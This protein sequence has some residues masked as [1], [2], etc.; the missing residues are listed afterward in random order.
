[1]KP[2]PETKPDQSAKQQVTTPE[3]SEKSAEELK[4]QLDASDMQIGQLVESNHILKIRLSELQHELSSLKDQ[5]SGDEELQDEIKKFLAQQRQMKVAQETKPPSMLDDIASSPLMLAM[6]ALLPAGL[7]AGLIALFLMRRKKNEEETPQLEAKTPPP[8]PEDDPD[9]D[10]PD[11]GLDD[12]PS[13]GLDDELELSDDQDGSESLEDMLFDE[14]GADDEL[15]DDSMMDGAGVIDEDSQDVDVSASGSEAL[16]M[17]DMER[18]I[19]ELDSG[20]E[21]EQDE[22]APLSPDE[23]LAAMWEQSLADD[24]DQDDIDA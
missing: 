12:E 11:L 19:N 7:I 2:S 24:S 15:F 14:S 18:A 1:M 8:V 23:E 20:T 3:V 5:M 13:L 6:L 9:L 10:E 4:A 17:D 22:T 16:G 21:Q